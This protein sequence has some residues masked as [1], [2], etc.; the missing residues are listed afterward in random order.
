MF[1]L[2]GHRHGKRV[3]QWGKFLATALLLTASSTL[4]AAGLYY[5]LAEQWNPLALLVGA[6]AG[7]VASVLTLVMAL[8]TPLQRLP[9]IK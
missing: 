9:M 1:S 8:L 3:V 6:G 7:F 5:L 2:V 4:A